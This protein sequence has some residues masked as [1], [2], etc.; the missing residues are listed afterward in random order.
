MVTKISKYKYQIT[1]CFLL[2]AQIISVL[3]ACGGGTSSAGADSH[4]SFVADEKGPAR[5]YVSDTH[6]M[7]QYDSY[8]GFCEMEDGYYLLTSVFSFQGGAGKRLV[9]LDRLLSFVGDEEAPSDAVDI[10]MA[11]GE[12]Y[13]LLSAESGYSV[14]SYEDEAPLY[15][16]PQDKHEVRKAL[17]TNGAIYFMNANGVWCGDQAIRLP[18]PQIGYTP[19][20][21][22]MT[23]YRDKLILFYAEHPEGYVT[24][25][26][27]FYAVSIEGLD[28]GIPE[29]WEH[30][31]QHFAADEDRL[32]FVQN[33]E[34]MLLEDGILT[35]CGS[36][37]GMGIGRENLHI[38]LFSDELYIVEENSIYRLFEADTEEKTI[39]VGCYLADGLVYNILTDYN[40]RADKTYRVELR[41]FEDEISLNRAVFSKE[42]DLLLTSSKSVDK[43]D[44]LSANARL[45]SLDEVLN[46][47]TMKALLP[48]VIDA[49][50]T[51]EGLYT[52]P[53]FFGLDGLSL[54]QS[55]MDDKTYFEDSLAFD[56]LL[57]SLSVQNFYQRQTRTMAMQNLFGFSG[58][59]EW[60]DRD[61]GKCSFDS[62]TFVRLLEIAGRFVKDA[63]AIPYAGEMPDRPLLCKDNTFGTPSQFYSRTC[64]TYEK[65]GTG[66][67]YSKYGLAAQ[68][69]PV[70]GIG[71][72]HGLAIS[73]QDFIAVVD[74][75]GAAV[76]TLLEYL[77]SEEIQRKFG[78]AKQN[79]ECASIVMRQDILEESIKESIL[80]THEGDA[81][82]TSEQRQQ[83]ADEARAYITGADHIAKGARTAV[84]TIVLEEANRYFTGEITAE[85]AAEYIQN[86][87][88]LYL[89]EQG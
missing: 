72:Y 36:L 87:V 52:L 85:K 88:Q 17:F 66:Q 20:L 32:F 74:G 77:F 41:R 29:K 63:D 40:R 71:K 27:A 56:N 6:T 75:K 13:Y 51:K 35:D 3:T 45:Q 19:W 61:N 18:E 14:R 68:L 79:E 60:V 1:G 28:C 54:P 24:G 89:D 83:N 15:T 21:V 47:E 59:D 23:L 7:T 64:L 58:F 44:S 81:E 69:F 42:I 43:L 49:C 62:P 25:E 9:R 70:P 22:D 65:R 73:S 80:T 5:T 2:I 38:F 31:A 37:Q 86:R 53:V 76:K 48:N 34:L 10:F 46:D 16:W 4:V 11:D 67:P 12:L 30:A 39:V 55:V 8:D 50:R 57:S 82:I 26:V 78:I 84:G 33:E